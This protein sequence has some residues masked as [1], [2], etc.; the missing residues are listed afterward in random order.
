M[1]KTRTEKKASLTCGKGSSPKKSGDLG[2][3]EDVPLPFKGVGGGREKNSPGNGKKR[4][5]VAGGRRIFSSRSHVESAE[6][7]AERVLLGERRV[8]KEKTG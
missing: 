3:K 1:G 8:A 4:Q 7:D 2:V 6:R 5:S